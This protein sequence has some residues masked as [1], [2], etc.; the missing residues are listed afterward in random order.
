MRLSMAAADATRNVVNVAASMCLGAKAR[1]QRSE[2]AAKHSIAVLLS[3]IV[4]RDVPPVLA[5]SD[6]GRL[7]GYEVMAALAS[8]PE[9]GR[10]AGPRHPPHRTRTTSSSLTATE[11]RG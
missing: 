1:R 8:L 5:G 7:S 6:V 10:R 2:L 11:V 4:R 9:C 3:T